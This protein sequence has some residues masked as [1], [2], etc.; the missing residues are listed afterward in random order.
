MRDTPLTRHRDGREGTRVQ[1]VPLQLV[2]AGWW[3]D[4]RAK[5]KR[6]GRRENHA[7]RRLMPERTPGTSVQP[8]CDGA[9][10]KSVPWRRLGCQ[11]PALL[12]DVVVAPSRVTDEPQAPAN[13]PPDM[14]FPP[15]NPCHLVVVNKS[16]ANIEA[17][18][19]RGERMTG[20]MGGTK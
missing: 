13:L 15:D 18:T 19:D 9:R 6:E 11:G 1:A 8:V 2:P 7:H 14:P 16:V 20:Q 4:N 12:G 5:E 3:K 10:A 17:E